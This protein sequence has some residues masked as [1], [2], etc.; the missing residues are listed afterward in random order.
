MRSVFDQLNWR[1]DTDASTLVQLVSTQLDAQEK[2]R[3]RVR[4]Q[5]SGDYPPDALSWL[6]TVTWSAPTLVPLSSFDLHGIADWPTWDDK[7]KIRTFIDK[8][9]AGWHKPIVAIKTPGSRYLT[10]IDGHTR[11]SVYWKLKRP[12]LAWVGKAHAQRGPWEDFHQQQRG[13]TRQ[14][15]A[16]GFTSVYGQLIELDNF[17]PGG[18][19]VRHVRSA[20]G[21]AFFH[22]PIG[23]PITEAEYQALLAQRR[24]ARASKP[25][26]HP[27]RIAAERAV[28]QARK[29]RQAGGNTDTANPGQDAVAQ[30]VQEAQ[31][32]AEAALASVTT[33]TPETSAAKLTSHADL[34]AARREAQAQHP[35]G[36]PRRIAAERAVRKSRARTKATTPQPEALSA[37]QR[38][39]NASARTKA[40]ISQTHAEIAKT[41]ENPPDFDKLSPKLQQA[42]THLTNGIDK[43]TIAA[44]DRMVNHSHAF[45]QQEVTK[46]R[47]EIDSLRK[48]ESEVAEQKE[49][50][51]L[52]KTL[53]VRMAF[54]A[55]G[56]FF[57]MF[58][59]MLQLPLPD[60]AMAAVAL[61]P[62]ASREIVERWLKL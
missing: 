10:P 50:G 28:R 13:M 39:E 4:Q 45:T 33:N 1:I 34:L 18:P 36:H 52:N 25:A 38:L 23:T 3:Q 9:Q 44:L 6:P 35:P 29:L 61:M 37:P 60:L 14:Q 51:K 58:L 62:D 30:E 20:R 19:A 17:T 40:A 49:K 42:V 43:G 53:L 47:E 59:K 56:I 12:V 8:I 31:Q 5:L 24:A 11:L 32:S 46:L 27:D 57:D 16:A 21:V 7:E 55:V 48:A 41:I 2:I 22:E 15:K 54:L 26:G